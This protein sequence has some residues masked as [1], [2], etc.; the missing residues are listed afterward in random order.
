MVRDAV[1]LALPLSPLCEEA[2]G[3]PDPEAHPVITADDEVVPLEDPRW[4]ALK[5]LRFD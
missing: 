5:E 3:G 1:L 4:A 2:C